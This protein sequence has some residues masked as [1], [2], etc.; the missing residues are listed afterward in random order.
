MFSIIF[1]VSLILKVLE[2]LKIDLGTMRALRTNADQI[3]SVC[4]LEQQGW[5]LVSSIQ[6]RE[7]LH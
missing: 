5:S 4:I 1:A 6:Q 2:K 3:S 7:A